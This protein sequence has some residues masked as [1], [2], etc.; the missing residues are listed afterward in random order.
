MA[1]ADL[2]TIATEHGE[3]CLVPSLQQHGTQHAAVAADHTD[4]ITTATGQVEHM[5]ISATT[6]AA[7]SANPATYVQ[8]QTNAREILKRLR[9][10]I[11]WNSTAACGG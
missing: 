11:M 1:R 6:D 8:A 5:V 9:Q 3:H 4:G 2:N 7:V 10:E